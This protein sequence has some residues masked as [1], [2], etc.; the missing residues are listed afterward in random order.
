MNSKINYHIREQDLI[1]SGIISKK[2]SINTNINKKS[3]LK[4]VKNYNDK[5]S[6]IKAMT[7]SH[8]ISFKLGTNVEFS[9]KILDK[10][11][12]KKSKDSLFIKKDI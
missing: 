10:D 5:F 11:D 1:N 3:Y 12:L 8:N 9:N 4:Y 6:Q 2:N 7:P